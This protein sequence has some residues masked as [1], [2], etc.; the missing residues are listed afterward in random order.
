MTYRKQNVESSYSC[1]MNQ[2]MKD[3]HCS[4]EF[5]KVGVEEVNLF[6]LSINKDKPPGTDNLDGKLLR[7]VVE[8]IVTPVC[9]IF[10]L[11]IEDMEGGKGLSGTQE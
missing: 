7:L 4:F 3:K 10:N 5:H 2:I 8:Y 11:S 9:H 6:L 1:I